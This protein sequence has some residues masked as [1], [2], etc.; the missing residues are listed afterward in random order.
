[1][2]AE[3]PLESALREADIPEQSWPVIEKLM[4]SVGI[5]RYEAIPN[6]GYVRAFR[7][8][9]K[10]WLA[11]YP[12]YVYGFQSEPEIIRAVGP[13]AIV[14]G[15]SD[16][17]LYQVGYKLKAVPAIPAKGR[18]RAARAGTVAKAETIGASSVPR[19]RN[20]EREPETCP[21]CWQQ[22]AADGTCQCEE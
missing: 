19:K 16:E 6:K 20:A 3:N 7:R 17:E 10:R 11:I 4:D 8:D 22:K 14:N 9:G 2:G 12:Q 15:P 21:E 13:G 18:K 5:T 1:M